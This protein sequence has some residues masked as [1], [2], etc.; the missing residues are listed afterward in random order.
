MNTKNLT[1][2]SIGI[3]ILMLGGCGCN[4]YNG[5]ASGDQEVKKVWSNVE[6]NYQRRTDL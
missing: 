3:F 2:I 1:L 5:L 6:T 4:S